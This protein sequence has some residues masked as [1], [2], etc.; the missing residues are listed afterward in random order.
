VE[1]G[2]TKKVKRKQQ[3]QLASGIREMS[4]EECDERRWRSARSE[5]KLP[6]E[7]TTTGTS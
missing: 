7:G 3:Q 6:I 2:L 4:F 5:V 1:A